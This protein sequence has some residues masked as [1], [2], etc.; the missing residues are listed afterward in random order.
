[1]NL[2]IEIIDGVAY[3]EKKKIF[4]DGLRGNKQGK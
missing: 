3:D 1:M 2:I 4:A